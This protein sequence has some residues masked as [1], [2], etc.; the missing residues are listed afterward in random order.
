MVP[1]ERHITT[2][3]KTNN[4]DSTLQKKSAHYNKTIEKVLDEKS[5]PSI[6]P[7]V[8]TWIF[9]ILIIGAGIFGSGYLIY[10]DIEDG[11]DSGF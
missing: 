7:T 9:S 6:G 1:L 4:N 5:N 3:L 2:L 11:N 8:F 10:L